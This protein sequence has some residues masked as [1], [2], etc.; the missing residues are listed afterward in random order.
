MKQQAVLI[1]ITDPTLHSEASHVA[2]ATGREV[3]STEDPREISRFAQKAAAV[4]VDATTAQHVASLRT[5]NA[6]LLCAEPGPVNW[7]LAMEIHAQAAMLLPAQ[8]PELLAL[9]GRNDEPPPGEHTAILVCGAAGGA[10]STT[11][12]SSL[13]ATMANAVLIDGD[14]YSGGCDLA[15]GIEQQP[16]LRWNDLG[17]DVA[18]VSGEELARALPQWAGGIPVLTGVRGGECSLHAD[19]LQ[20]TT[21][22]L[23]GAMDVILDVRLGSELAQAALEVADVAV[24]II[25][26]EVRAAAAAAQVQRALQQRH[27]AA[28]GVLRHRAWSG[29]DRDEAEDISGM[30]IV[31]E[32]PNIS[33]LS[34][35]MELEGLQEVPKSLQRTATTILQSLEAA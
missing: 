33:R 7:Q 16:G 32:L 13:A 6:V 21:R 22:A 5:Q 1:A 12:A 26:A 4:L 31:A 29:L 30:R 17:D 11:L 34:K 8:A 35:L 3:I 25:P 24:V 2:A 27:M 18:E 19:K 10:G 28:V 23:L 20:A 15:L 14:P 9:I